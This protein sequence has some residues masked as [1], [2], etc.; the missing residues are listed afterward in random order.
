MLRLSGFDGGAIA[1]GEIARPLPAARASRWSFFGI[2]ALIFAVAAAVTVRECVSMAAMGE[3]PMPGGWTLSMMWSPMCGQTG[4]GTD[5]CFID[6]WLVMMVTMML[7]A[8]TPTLWSYRET[9]R[10]RVGS[11]ADWLTVLVG[12]GYFT[13][14]IVLGVAVFAPGAVLAYAVLHYATL[15]RAVPLTVGAIVLIGGVLQFSAW[16]AHH[17]A[18]CR[19]APSCDCRLPTSAVGAWRHG[20][21]LGL[22]CVNACANLTAILLVV[23]MMDLCAMVLVTA[24][25]TA[26]RLAANGLY[27][28]RIA[29]AVA[30]GTGL[31]FVAQAVLRLA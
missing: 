22:H 15:A 9:I 30:V 16:K 2:C 31:S 27:V 29:G 11:R 18:C 14:W 28:A 5:V 12:L 23:G 13:V 8:L 21:R 10:A 4:W 20:L 26:E 3:T 17:L 25:I 1:V 7:P 24:A 6:M 19:A